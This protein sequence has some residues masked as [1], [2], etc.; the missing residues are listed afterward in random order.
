MTLTLTVLNQ[1]L[2]AVLKLLFLGVLIYLVLI[3]RNLDRLIRSFEKSAES[4]ERTSE[5]IGKLITVSRYIPFVGGR[6]ER[7]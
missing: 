6:R 4:I 3:L 5:K 7:D 1:A 2:D